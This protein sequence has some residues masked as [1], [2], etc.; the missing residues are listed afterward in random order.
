MNFR[1]KPLILIEKSSPF[2]FLH[3][4]QHLKFGSFPAVSVPIFVIMKSL[5]ALQHE[6]HTQVKCLRLETGYSLEFHC[7]PIESLTYDF[8]RDEYC[9]SDL[10]LPDDED[11]ELPDAVGPES[12]RWLEPL[13]SEGVGRAVC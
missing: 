7:P 11:D 5:D 10:A 8:A 6:R 13:A 2:S 12:L 1:N 3:F 4:S 9:A